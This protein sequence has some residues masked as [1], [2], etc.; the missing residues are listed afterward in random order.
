MQL[1]IASRLYR[2]RL[3]KL[4]PIQRAAVTLHVELRC[5]TDDAAHFCKLGCG[6][7]RFAYG[8][9]VSDARCKL[10]EYRNALEQSPGQSAGGIY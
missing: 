1:K 3:R 9:R 5:R 8:R 2:T 6:Y 10:V 4:T 7:A